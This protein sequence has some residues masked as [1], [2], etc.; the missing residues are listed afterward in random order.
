MTRID[1]KDAASYQPETREQW[2]NR[3]RRETEEDSRRIDEEF[4][5][6]VWSTDILKE[7]EKFEKLTTEYRKALEAITSRLVDSY[8][9]G[10]D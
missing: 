7:P 3:I 2:L 9:H 4:K 5:A 8:V 1:P 10:P 6:A